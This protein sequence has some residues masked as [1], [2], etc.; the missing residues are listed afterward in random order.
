MNYI[1]PLKKQS[2]GGFDLMA[3]QRSFMHDRMPA[4]CATHLEEQYPELLPRVPDAC[5]NPEPQIK[6][7]VRNLSMLLLSSSGNHMC[8]GDGKTSCTLTR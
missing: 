4:E 3:S 6:K 1:M 8:L 5:R 7:N 2:A